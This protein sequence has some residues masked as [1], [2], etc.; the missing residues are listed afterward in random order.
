MAEQPRPRLWSDFDGT[1]VEIVGKVNPRNWSKYPLAGMP[2][3]VDFLRGVRNSG[4]DV[5]GVVSRRPNILPRRFVTARSVAQLGLGEFFE[6]SQL[7]CAGS[8]AAK[9][10]FVVEQS[11]EARVAIVD[12]KPHRAGQAVV[13]AL[14]EKFP[15]LTDDTDPTT[16]PQIT[17]GVVAHPKSAEYM[18]RFI[19]ELDQN[20]NLDQVVRMDS[21]GMQGVQV[22]DPNFELTVLQ[23]EPYSIATGHQFAAHLLER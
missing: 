8:E 5:A 20:D 7:V 21:H 6:P 16:R 13:N 10:Q 19:D 17:V 2:G 23:L 9:G 3:Y 22:S 15:V 12:D 4:V 18:S 1:A 11:A 14:L